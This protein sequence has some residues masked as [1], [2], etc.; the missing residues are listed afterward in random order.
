MTSE[1]GAARPAVCDGR[2]GGDVYQPDFG[3]LLKQ[4]RSVRRRSQLDLAADAEVSARHVSFLETGRSRPS[5]EMVLVLASALE[6]PLRDR[7]V[8]LASAGFSPAYA[9]TGLDEA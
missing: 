9:E 3:H 6:V 5:R 2:A 4:W 8:L 7:N 1:V